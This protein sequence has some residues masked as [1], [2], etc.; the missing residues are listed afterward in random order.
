MKTPPPS[1]DDEPLV[2]L[3]LFVLAGLCVLAGIASGIPAGTVPAILFGALF[4]CSGALA[5][6]SL[7]V[8]IR[9]LHRIER[10]TRR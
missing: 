7:A 5:C 2:V 10:N 1:D 4:G 6:W 9:L 8:I 3:V